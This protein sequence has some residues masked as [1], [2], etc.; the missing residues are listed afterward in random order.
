MIY[1]QYYRKWELVLCRTCGSQGMHMA[2]GQL[3]WANPVWE[4]EECISIT[5]G[6]YLANLQRKKICY[7]SV[8]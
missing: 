7:I 6:K 3:K 1:I 5:S 4:C 2:C 8:H